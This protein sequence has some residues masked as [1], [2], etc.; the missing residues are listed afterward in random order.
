M[1]ITELQKIQ[2]LLGRITNLCKNLDGLDVIA[3]REVKNE[4][5]YIINEIADNLQEQVITS[6][7]I[8]K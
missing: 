5:H 7:K 8:K 2:T 3:A 4:I 6:S 1:S